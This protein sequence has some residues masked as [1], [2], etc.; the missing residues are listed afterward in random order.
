MRTKVLKIA[1]R[2]GLALFA[3]VIVSSMAFGGLPALAATTD[4]EW[5]ADKME[6]AY[7]K[8][9]P[10]R[11]LVLLSGSLE[12]GQDYYVRYFVVDSWQHSHSFT[13]SSSS[14]TLSGEFLLA[15]RNG[16]ET[17]SRPFEIVISDGLL[18]MTDE[19][20]YSMRNV[21]FAYFYT[22]KPSKQTDMV[23]GFLQVFSDIA[24]WIIEFIP[25]AISV[26]Y[27]AEH[28]FT[29]LGIVLVVTVSLSLGIVLVYRIYKWLRR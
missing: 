13:L 20:G 21:S 7:F 6:V 8:R 5:L 16:V 23:S 17:I 26:F 27:T 14:D 24:D 11:G 25:L 12:P 29:L 18:S 2:C 3:L 22:Q 19:D 10:S 1:K 4:E 15:I 28:G 9:D